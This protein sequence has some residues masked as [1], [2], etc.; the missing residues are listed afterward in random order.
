MATPV[1]RRVRSR[2][3]RTRRCIQSISN[4]RSWGFGRSAPRAFGSDPVTT[5]KGVCALPASRRFWRPQSGLRSVRSFRSAEAPKCRFDASTQVLAAHGQFSVL[6]TSSA[7][8][9]RVHARVCVFS[10]NSIGPKLGLESVGLCRYRPQSTRRRGSPED[11]TGGS[12]CG[13]S[14]PGCCSGRG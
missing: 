12:P 5:G 2:R 8:W 9:Q 4:D 7:F 6:E 11:V 13:N 1:T 3:P 14:S 10:L